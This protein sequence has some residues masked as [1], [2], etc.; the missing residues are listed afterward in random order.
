MFEAHLVLLS[1][2]NA[3]DEDMDIDGK[4]DFSGNPPSGQ[5]DD[6]PS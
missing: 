5:I 3:L 1:I 4:W 2:I 6:C